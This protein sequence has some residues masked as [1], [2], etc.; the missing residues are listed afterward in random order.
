MNV[1]I[2]KS[3]FE[4]LNL[5]QIGKYLFGSQLHGIAKKDSDYDYVIVLNDILYKRFDTKAIYLPNFHSYQYDCEEGNTQYVLMTE[6]QFYRNLFSGDGNMIAD[7]ILL[8]ESHPDYENRMHLCRT[9]KIIKGYLGVAK[10]DLKMHGNDKKKRYHA[11]RSLAMAEDLIDNVKPSVKMIKA[12]HEDFLIEPT[13]K[14]D[15]L[16]DESILRDTLNTMLNQGEIDLYPNF[17]EDN[18]LI[19]IMTNSNN[20][21]E[22]KY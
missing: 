18:E 20:I 6:T 2:N 12:L 9:Y 15:L 1:K 17:K 10:R 4:Y 13:T 22:F 16:R 21:R 11:F 19:Q 8:N 7:I 14:E 5:Y 3:Q